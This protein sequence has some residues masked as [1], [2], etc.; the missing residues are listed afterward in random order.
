MPAVDLRELVKAPIELT[1]R[2]NDPAHP[3]TLH[4]GIGSNH[5]YTSRSAPPIPL[6]KG[7]RGFERLK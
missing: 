7:G 2:F 4:D 1:G 3:H 6:P 5:Q